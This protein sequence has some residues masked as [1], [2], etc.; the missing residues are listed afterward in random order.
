VEE[1]ALTT[2][3]TATTL[4]APELLTNLTQVAVLILVAAPAEVPSVSSVAIILVL[5]F[6]MS[7]QL[8]SQVF[9]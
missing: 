8:F 9:F 6:T 1:A 3:L 7:F 4:T 2:V 5:I